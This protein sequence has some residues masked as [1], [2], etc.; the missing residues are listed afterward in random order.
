[1]RKRLGAQDAIALL[2]PNRMLRLKIRVLVTPRNA[3]C[4]EDGVL[5]IPRGWWTGSGGKWSWC[6][7]VDAAAVDE[8]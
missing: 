8:D 5:P 1:M 4:D 7:G 3:G 6:K 2:G